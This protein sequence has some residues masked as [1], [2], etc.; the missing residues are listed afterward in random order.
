[1][2]SLTRK[3]PSSSSRY[4]LGINDTCMGLILFFELPTWNCCR[5]GVGT[6]V[7]GDRVGNIGFQFPRK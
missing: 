1:M 6:G 5:A 3:K 7:W 4:C 2:S